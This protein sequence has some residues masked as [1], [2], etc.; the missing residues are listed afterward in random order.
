MDKSL[1]KSLLGLCQSD[2]EKECLR[3][4]V[5]KA[6]GLSS[7]QARAKFGLE[8]MN[9]RAKNVK[10]C[11]ILAQYIRTAIK[12]LAFT[13]DKA[14][15]RSLGLSC[16]N[17]E[18]SS[19]SSD[20]ESSDVLLNATVPLLSLLLTAF[21]LNDM[22][23]IIQE[24]QR[25]WFKIVEQLETTYGTQCSHINHLEESIGHLNISV[26]EKEKLRVSYEALLLNKKDQAASQREADI[27]NG[28]IVTESDSDDPDA[29]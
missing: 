1:L 20:E 25:N 29:F 9:L 17:E 5:F 4:A 16:G 21:S 14:M 10:D 3:F 11:L 2:K 7:T 27:Y 12:T 28:E 26:C 24:C 18:L 15:L 23:V 19:E 6:S 8:N 13:T 22:K